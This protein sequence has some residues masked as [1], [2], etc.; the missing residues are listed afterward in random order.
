MCLP[1]ELHEFA[2]KEARVGKRL[3]WQSLLLMV[4]TDP[5]ALTVKMRN[6]RDKLLTVTALQLAQTKNSSAGR[7]AV[8]RSGMGNWDSYKTRTFKPK[9]TVRA[10]L[11]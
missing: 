9:Q 8:R 5:S 11:L 1:P 3:L 2:K 6:T 10:L 4:A 7:T